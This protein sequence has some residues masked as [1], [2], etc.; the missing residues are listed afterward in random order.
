MTPRILICAFLL[1]AAGGAQAASE[2][3]REHGPAGARTH[4]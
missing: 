4:A 2:H 1:V 3:A